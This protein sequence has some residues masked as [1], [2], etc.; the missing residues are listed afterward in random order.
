MGLIFYQGCGGVDNETHKPNTQ[1]S[2]VAF[3]MMYILGRKIGRM[4][5]A[6][7]WEQNIDIINNLVSEDFPKK[8]AQLAS[9]ADVGVKE[10]K[11][12]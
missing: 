5:D 10:I 11:N 4:E 8:L 1:A 9:R 3:Q 7:G 2:H 6:H 12:E